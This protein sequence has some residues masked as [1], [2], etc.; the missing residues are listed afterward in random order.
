MKGVVLGAVDP[1]LNA[2]P[3]PGPPGL[4]EKRTASD[5]LEKLQEEV[6]KLWM[7]MLISKGEST[8]RGGL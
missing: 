5:S 2:A 3:V 8:T 1:S 4:N 7:E 6:A